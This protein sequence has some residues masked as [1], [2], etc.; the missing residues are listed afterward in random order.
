MSRRRLLQA[1]IMDHLDLRLNN[2]PADGWRKG[3]MS[4]TWRI[5]GFLMP[6]NRTDGRRARRA[7]E[8]GD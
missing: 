1:I 4:W 3:V 7:E 5:K 2:A 8:D 6:R